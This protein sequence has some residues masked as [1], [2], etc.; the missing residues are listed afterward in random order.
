MNAKLISQLLYVL[1]GAVY[2]VAGLS[3]MLMG[4][5]V[6]PP[7]LVRLID[8]LT[9]YDREVLHVAQEFGTHLVILGLVTLWFVRHY[10]QSG[11]FHWAMTLGWAL[12]ALIHWRD[13]RGGGESWKGPAITTI[14]LMAFLVVGFL[15]RKG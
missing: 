8:H 15:R 3:L 4:T 5:N 12:F 11:L 14:P 7:S 9:H 13:I 1:F 10:E 2:L 6:L